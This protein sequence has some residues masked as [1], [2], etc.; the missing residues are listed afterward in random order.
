MRRF[1]PLFRFFEIGAS[2]LFH[3]CRLTLRWL[4]SRASRRPVSAQTLLGDELRLLCERLGATFVKL[5]QVLSSRPDLLTPELTAPLARLQDDVAPFPGAE[6]AVEHAFGRSL[7]EIFAHFEP[8][9]MASASIAQVHRARLHDGREVAV[10]I[11][12]PGIVQQVDDDFR[13][14]HGIA[15]WI[16]SLPPMRLVPMRELIQELETPIRQQLDFY[17]EV[18]SLE[19]FRANFEG[20]EHVT[21]PVPVR[22]L[23]SASVLTMELLRDLEKV[24]SERFSERERKTAALAGLRALYKMIFADG[25][26]HADMHPGNVF[27]R[28]WGE[29]V[30]LDMGLVAELSDDDLQDFVDFFFGLVNNQGKVC[31]QI[32]YDTALY[33]SPRCDRQAFETAIVEMVGR[34]SALKSH[35]FEVTHFVYELIETQRRHGIRGSTQFIMTVLSMVVYDGICKQLYP[36][37]EFQKEARGYL[38]AA[39]Y[40]RHQRLAIAV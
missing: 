33:V 16:G 7:P 24:T 30:I 36:E 29:L 17:R 8:E 15:R 26:V 20:V 2:I 31:A 6:S 40:R 5:G 32:V 10:K 3:G 1:S 21:L 11:R 35:E 4:I 23:C 39:K 27:L 38:I 12:R 37:C 18:A 19:R 14:M 9:P 13:M 34:H 25:F 28:Q 22:E